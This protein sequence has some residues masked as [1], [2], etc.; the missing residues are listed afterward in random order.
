VYQLAM[1]SGEDRRR[2]ADLIEQLATMWAESRDLLD[3]EQFD[4]YR[5][6]RQQIDEYTA[7]LARLLPSSGESL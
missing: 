3:A 7:E 5:T 6:L 2:A 1:L 4:D